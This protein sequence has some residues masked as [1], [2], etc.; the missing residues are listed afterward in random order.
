MA[1]PIGTDYEHFV[2]QR[3]RD[4]SVGGFWKKAVNGLLQRFFL[5]VEVVALES[6]AVVIEGHRHKAFAW[7]I[8]GGHARCVVLG[9]PEQQFGIFAAGDVEG[10]DAGRVGIMV[11]GH[12]DFVGVVLVEEAKGGERLAG[13]VQ[14]GDG[15]ADW[16]P[17]L[18]SLQTGVKNDGIPAIVELRSQTGFS[19]EIHIIQPQPLTVAEYHLRLAGGHIHLEGVGNAILVVIVQQQDVVVVPAQAGQHRGAL[20]IL[21]PFAEF[22]APIHPPGRQGHPVLASLVDGG[23]PPNKARVHANVLQHIHILPE[24]DHQPLVVRPEETHDF[25]GLCSQG[26]RLGAQVGGIVDE[27][28]LVAILAEPLHGGHG[29]AIWGNGHLR[30]GRIHGELFV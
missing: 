7:D 15:L 24:I 21:H 23:C 25:H 4:D 27:Q 2:I 19:I 26:H 22:T 28:V 14:A 12:P 9:V 3:A 18:L 30:H 1:R 5:G 16:Q 8:L 13:C 17:F 10:K 11:G 20:Q 6:L 29:L